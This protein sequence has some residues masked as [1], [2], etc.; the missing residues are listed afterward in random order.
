M[1]VPDSPGRNGKTT[2]APPRRPRGGPDPCALA[3]SLIAAIPAA[4]GAVHQAIGDV[5]QRPMLGHWL[6]LPH[7]MVRAQLYIAYHIT[8]VVTVSRWFEQK[9]Q[10]GA[11][12]VVAPSSDRF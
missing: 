10:G 9:G 7:V 6:S 4:H 3:S 11:N 1:G 2:I 5:W 12:V 8:L